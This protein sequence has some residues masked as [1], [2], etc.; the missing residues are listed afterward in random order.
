MRLPGGGGDGRDFAGLLVSGFRVQ[1][2]E[3]PQD[4]QDLCLEACTTCIGNNS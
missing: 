2:S 1:G 3:T 4:V